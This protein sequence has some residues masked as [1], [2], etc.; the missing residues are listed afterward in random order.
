MYNKLL[1]LKETGSIRLEYCCEECGYMVYKPVIGEDISVYLDRWDDYLN[2]DC[3]FCRGKTMILAGLY[4]E[5]E[6][7]ALHKY[8]EG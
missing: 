2:L 3:P 5:E 1:K 8:A 7:V 4:S 6:W